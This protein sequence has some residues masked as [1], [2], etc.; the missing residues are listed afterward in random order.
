MKSVSNDQQAFLS[1]S[2]HVWVLAPWLQTDDPTL[3]YYYDYSQAL[4]ELPKA[5]QELGLAWTWKP[6]TIDDFASTIDAISSAPGPQLVFNMCDGDEIN[7]VPGISVVKHLDRSGLIFTGAR[8]SF[9]EV[10][11]SKIW[12][13]EAFDK[14]KVPT[15]EWIQT[16]LDAAKALKALK[17]PL[18]VKPALSGGSMG[19]SINSVV[20]NI[21]E[22]EKQIEVLQKGCHGWKT[23]ERG[24]YVEQFVSGREFTALIVG[25]SLRP[26]EATL[27]EPV[28]RVFDASLPEHE[29][30]LSFDRIWE[31]YENETPLPNEAPLYNYGPVNDPLLA[32]HIK[33]LSWQAYAAVDGTGYGRVDLRLDEKTG[34][35]LVLEV[36]A[37]CGLSEDENFTS[38]G[39]ILRFEKRSFSELLTLIMMN[40]VRESE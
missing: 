36:N 32:E 40:A 26:D 33:R 25:S 19:I 15:P 1:Q 28:E 9:Y 39:A 7:K 30:F 37:Q 17:P 16:H 21:D 8:E 5:F 3:Q 6:V 34:K 11:T 13:K 14:A 23:A 31:F 38:I 29:R 18:I 20:R 4:T 2:W 10:T 22:L 24:I 12:M 27:Y 35:L